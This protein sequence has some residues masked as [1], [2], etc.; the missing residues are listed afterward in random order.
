VAKVAG[1]VDPSEDA[2]TVILALEG[3][4]RRAN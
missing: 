4:D 3:F 1:V 2:R